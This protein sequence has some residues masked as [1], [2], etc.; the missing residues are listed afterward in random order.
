MSKRIVAQN[1]VV[2]IGADVHMNKHVVT[3]KARGEIVGTEHLAPTPEAWKTYLKRFPGCDVRVVYESGPQGYNLYDWLSEMRCESETTVSVYVAPP[4]HVP[5]APGKRIKTDKRDSISLIHALE[6]K[7][8]RPVVVPD[9]RVREERELVRTR[10]QMKGA[11]KRIMN[12]VHGMI[13]FHGV[14]YPE[15]GAWSRAWL[16]ELEANVKAAD[17]TGYLL[18]SFMTKLEVYRAAAEA[19]KE[20]DKKIREIAREGEKREVAV[21]LQK[22][23]GVGWHSAAIIATEVADFGAFNNSGC[24][25]SYVGLVPSEHSSGDCVKRG[26]ITKAGNHRLRRIFIEC[27]WV[28]IRYDEEARRQYCRIRMGKRERTKIAITAVARKLAVKT[29]HMA[30]NHPP[31]PT[32]KTD[33]KK[34]A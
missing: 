33:S 6:M 7:S 22:I 15:S 30:R 9:R 34:A 8:F 29:Y 32:E 3:A 2:V 11:Q 24:F 17:A 10:E 1:E 25:A 28:W 20:L 31:L 26:R 13:K 23:P 16:S 14:R 21:K 27:A 12:Q 4:A 18:I 5:K 19:I